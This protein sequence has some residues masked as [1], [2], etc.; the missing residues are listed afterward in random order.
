M[1]L[2]LVAEVTPLIINTSSDTMVCPYD[3]L[4]IELQ[5]RWKWGAIII[6]GQQLVE[7]L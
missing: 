3:G 6:R 1:T 2:M 7:F 4:D 5:F